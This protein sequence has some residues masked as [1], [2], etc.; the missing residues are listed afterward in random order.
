VQDGL[1]C[2]HPFEGILHAERAAR[3]WVSVNS[4]KVAA[5]DLNADAVTGGEA[6]AARADRDRVLVNAVGIEQ[7]RPVAPDGR[8]LSIQE[9][10]IRALRSLVYPPGGETR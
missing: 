2:R 1:A 6:V 3:I 5:G 7:L 10:V 4:R 8:S 9:G